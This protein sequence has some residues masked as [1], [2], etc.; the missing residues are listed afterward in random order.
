MTIDDDGKIFVFYTTVM[1]HMD[2][3]VENYRHVWA[4]ANVDGLW[5]DAV[6]VNS[7]IVHN[8]DECI[9]PSVSPTTD[10]NV[11]AL[12]QADEEPGMA[13]RGSDPA[14][15]YTDN[16]QIV[17]K[18]PKT[19]LTIGIKDQPTPVAY[20]SQNI[21]N[22]TNGTTMFRV[23]VMK[24]TNLSVEVMNAVG[25]KVF[26]IPSTPAGA[27]THEFTLDVTRYEAGI[28]FYTVTAGNS[29]VTKKMIV[30]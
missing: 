15:P 1:E 20:V 30:Q 9:Y 5:K 7:S 27:G 17:T 11:Y 2:N 18:V 8:F 6:N 24:P 13:V 25:Q 29:K 21:P 26:E 3:G 22:P 4:V 12:F 28:Y 16:S 10:A 23:S 19:D 14:D